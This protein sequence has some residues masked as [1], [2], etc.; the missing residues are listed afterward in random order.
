M[1]AG[2]LWIAALLVLAAT[3]SAGANSPK[4]SDTARPS[5]LE[6]VATGVDRVATVAEKQAGAVDRGCKAGVDLRDSDLCA[7]WKAADAAADSARWAWVAAWTSIVG[8]CAVLGAFLLAYQ[9]NR[10]A[11]DT[12]KAQLRAY[13]SF[14]EL[15]FSDAELETRKI[16]IEWTNAGQTPAKHALA[17]ASWRDFPE[18]LPADFDFPREV[19]AA[20]DGPSTIGPGQC[21]HTSPTERL[22]R[23]LIA[24]AAEGRANVIL[25]SSVDYVDTFGTARRSEFAA[26]LKAARLMNGDV[27]AV[28]AALDRHNGIDDECFHKPA[29]R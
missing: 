18:G 25:W 8:T 26:K 16:Q 9:A 3:T 23:W 13:V 22:P 28:W 6:Q 24:E 14:Q 10:I 15:T 5:P 17:H 19:I 1:K 2:R 12:A 27:G 4:P 11:S 21:I 20:D 29:K 7:Q